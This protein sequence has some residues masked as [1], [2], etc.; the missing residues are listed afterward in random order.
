MVLR[1][2]SSHVY[3]LISIV[4]TRQLNFN[5]LQP[6]L[7]VQRPQRRAHPQQRRAQPQQRCMLLL[8]RRSF[9]LHALPSVLHLL[10]LCLLRLRLL[11]GLATS[12]LRQCAAGHGAL[13]LL[14][15]LKT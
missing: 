8:R 10:R 4:K 15:V 9:S 2:I 1:T 3:A 14:K 7:R 6:L 11:V 13:S 12:C 5:L